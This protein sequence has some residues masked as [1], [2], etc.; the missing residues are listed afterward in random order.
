MRRDYLLQ[1]PGSQ[2][3]RL[4]LQLDGKAVETSLYT[5]DRAVA[6]VRAYPLIEAHKRKLLERRP[7]FVETWQHELEPGRTHVNPDGG[8]I[9]ATADTLIYLDAAGN[10]TRTAPNGG[11]AIALTGG[12]LIVHSLAQA[13]IESTAFG[14][15]LPTRRTLATK[16]GDDDLIE[17]YLKHSG[18]GGYPAKECRDTWALFR[19]L[20]PGV[21]LAN[22]TRDH[23]RKLA[24]HFKAQG[25]KSATAQHKI[26]RLAAAC[27]FAIKEGRLTFNPFS[28][29]V[30]KPKKGEPDA[31]EKRHS[32]TDDD[33]AII[34]ANLDRLSPSDKLMVTILATTGMRLDEALQINSE[35]T[36]GGVRYTIIGT[37][38]EASERRVPFPADL[39]PLLPKAITGPLFPKD[40]AHAASMR[41]NSRWLRKVCGI[42]DPSKVIHSFR[43]RAQ[44]RLRA[45][46]VSKDQR[47]ELLGH[48][49][50]TVGEGYGEGYPVPMLKEWIDRIGL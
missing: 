24:E 15:A 31:S 27:N 2:N 16:N 40:T 7:Q 6:E 3:W 47:E 38:T 18:L 42:T 21:K 39:L 8:T 17:L 10:V 19:E 26:A 5:P 44:D 23:G 12:P 30:K 32:F 36:E 35:A 22:A 9:V 48:S 37:K 33:M 25:V 50:V 14:E 46:G 49:K 41:L 20:C 34:R 43:H 28:G 13:A 4:R 29:V 11:N 45:G 1:R